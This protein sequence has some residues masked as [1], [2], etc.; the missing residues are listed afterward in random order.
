[1]NQERIFSLEG[2][3]ALISGAGRGIGFAIAE[4]FAKSGCDV[5]IF[6]KNFPQ[7][8]SEK[9]KSFKLDLSISE[10]I[11]SAFEDFYDSFESIDILVNCAGIT[12]PNP[13][14]D[15][16]SEDWF[17]TMDINLNAIFYLTQLVG[18]K[19]IQQNSGGSIIN[20]T[21][22]GAEQGFPN[23]PAYCASK[24]GLKQLTKALAYDWGKYGIRV[25]N[26][27]PGYTNTPMNKKSWND[28]NLRN[29]RASSTLLNRWAEPEEMVGPA[30]FLASDA[31]SYVT[32]SDLVVDGGWIAKGL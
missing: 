25:N 18:N 22:I 21:S 14:E 29:K 16:I 10:Q 6:D 7:P 23:N 32:A 28:Q 15:Y 13:A 4:G 19:M 8:S 31:S 3:K 9:I 17:A 30:I 26:L 24:G 20:L 12:I 2:K 27:V 11:K 1:M 5:G